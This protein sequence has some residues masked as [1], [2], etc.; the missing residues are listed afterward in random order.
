MG[1]LENGS[2]AVG[3]ASGLDYRTIFESAADGILVVGADG[4]IV[5]VNPEALRQFGYEESDLVG[6]SIDVLVPKALAGTHVRHRERYRQDPSPRPMGIGLELCGARKDGTE[7]PVEISLSSEEAGGE[8]YVICVVRDMTERSQLRSL[9]I[10][11]IDAAERERR[12]IAQELHDDTAQ[13]LSGIILRLKLLVEEEDADSRIAAGEEVREQIREAAEGVR[14]IARGLRPPALEDAG[15]VTALRG[16]TQA[17][18]DRAEVTWELHSDAVDHLLSDNARLALYRVVQEAISN[19]VRHAGASK[20]EITIRDAD[21]C[22]VVKVSDDGCGFDVEKARSGSGLG[23]LGM[24]E[25]AAGV[26]G[27]LGYRSRPGEGSTITLTLP[28]DESGMLDG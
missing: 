26:G 25:R 24:R 4:T 16:H 28:T 12:R 6:R 2:V 10:E 13:L 11:A 23:L 1:D 22:V 5:D 20:L 9:G 21:E 7:F 18:L 17:F 27:T 8:R 14:R 15:I 3:R 19:V